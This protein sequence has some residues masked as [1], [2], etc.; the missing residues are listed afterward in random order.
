MLEFVKSVFSWVAFLPA[1]LMMI[2]IFLI[3]N[4]A[5]R[6]N[7]GKA[8]RS[9]LLYGVGLFGLLQF[10]GIFVST[11]SP[12]SQALVES[13]GVKMTA[14]DYGIGIV[15]VLLSNPSITLIIP[16]GI[17]FN[18]VLLII[19]WTKTMDLDIFNIMIFWGAP[20]ILVLIDTG[21]WL[22]AIL[23]GLVTG[24]ITL[25]L[26]DWSAPYIHKAFP[27]Y[28]GLSFPHLNAVFWTPFALWINRLFDAIPGFKD[29][30]IDAKSIK[31]R[32]GIVGEPIF[33]GLV[34]GSLLAALAGKNLKEVL[35]A[36]VSLGA[37]I[38]FIPVMIR[39]LMDGLNATSTVL[40]EWIKARYP[41]REVLIGL[42]AVLTVGHP[43]T[44]AVGLLLVPLWLLL[45]IILPGNT[46]LPF[47]MLAT[48]YITVCLVM[49]FFRMNV[50]R[51]VIMGIVI[52][53][54][55]LYLASMAAPYYTAIAA[56][57]ELPLGA[58]QVTIAC[59]P[60]WAV[61]VPVFRFIGS[62][63]GII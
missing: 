63:L 35:I 59:C 24:F 32:F 1:P 14:I 33:I 21:S 62:I 20:F 54:I 30:N 58:S 31:K 29:W 48:A 56:S 61:S 50:L 51:G 11:I 41:E 34:L 39:V 25:K 42:D 57:G 60:I 2:L 15:G 12:L 5:L 9:A 16:I 4:L 8:F 38:H 44:L 47:G 6:M 40:I 37:S 26:A 23:A 49:P 36:G 13:L 28:E 10:T 7:I 45:G 18:L 17:V 27:Q 55:N 43:E 52:F 22:L 19:G 53:A 46:T 3:I